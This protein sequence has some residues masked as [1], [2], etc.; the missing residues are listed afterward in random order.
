MYSLI[1]RI[2]IIS[3]KTLVNKNN[4]GKKF[5][6][7]PWCPY[8]FLKLLETNDETVNVKELNT[9][10][11]NPKLHEAECPL[12]WNLVLTRTTPASGQSGT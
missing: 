4:F 8:S 5:V 6:Q 7:F 9:M 10:V 11:K 3:W 1:M 2:I 12:G